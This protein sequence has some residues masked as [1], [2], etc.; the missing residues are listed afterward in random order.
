MHDIAPAA[1]IH[2]VGAF[3]CGG[4][5]DIALSS[6]LDTRSDTIVS[7]SYGNLGEAVPADAIKGQENQH[8]QA[9][10]EGIGLYYSSGDSGDET[11]NG[12][13]PSPTTRPARRG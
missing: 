10:A 9:V 5:I 11:P 6:I 3:N 13:T 1:A 2:Y 8:L 12:L 7:N 4:G